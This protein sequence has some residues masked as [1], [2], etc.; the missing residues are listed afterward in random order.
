MHNISFQSIWQMYDNDDEREWLQY[1]H[2]HT[3]QHIAWDSFVDA[4]RIHH[5]SSRQMLVLL[6]PLLVLLVMHISN[7]AV[8]CS[9]LLLTAQ[10]SCC[11]L[12]Q[13]TSNHIFERSA[14]GIQN[15][16]F[17]HLSHSLFSSHFVLVSLSVY[18][19]FLCCCSLFSCYV[20]SGFIWF[21][22]GSL[23]CLDMDVN[24]FDGRCEF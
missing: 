17:F 3:H 23:L 22:S 6:L 9:L 8:L 24:V 20:C 14:K 18:A 12:P 4:F 10:N 2:T 21:G 13:N 16:S 7:V 15:R 5:S 19:F 1:Q 11:A